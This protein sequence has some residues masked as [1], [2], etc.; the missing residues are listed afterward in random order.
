M[1]ELSIMRGHSEP[2]KE[3]RDNGSCRAWSITINNPTDADIESWKHAKALHWVKDAIGQLE[4]GQNGTLHIQGLLKTEKVRFAQVKK[5]FPRAH[6]E[7]ARNQNALEVYVQKPETRVASITPA[8]IATA[9][10]IQRQLHTE[11]LEFRDRHYSGMSFPEIRSQ[12]EKNWEA[13]LDSAVE[14]LMLQ[15]YYGAE[16]V[17]CNPQVRSAYRRYI[18]PM[19]IRDMHM[20]AQQVTAEKEEEECLIE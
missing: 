11:V 10:D 15:G 14:K 16:F 3:A 2:T 8:K 5:A 13:F 19:V 17:V 1:A 4:K 9:T 6:V 12:I 20:S 18:Y 7:P